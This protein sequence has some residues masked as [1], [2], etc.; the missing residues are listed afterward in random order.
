MTAEEAHRAFTG[1]PDL[2]FSIAEGNYRQ[3]DQRNGFQLHRDIE[4]VHRRHNSDDDDVEAF[5]SMSSSDARKDP[6]G[7]A[8]RRIAR[9]HRAH[10]LAISTR[11]R[12]GLES[13]TV[14]SSATCFRAIVQ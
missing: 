10:Q 4:I 5:S 8:L 2:P 11:N 14:I 7:V 1:L 9:T 6:C 13:R 12:V 3:S